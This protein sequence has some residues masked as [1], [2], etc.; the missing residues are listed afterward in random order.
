MV[1]EA[2]SRTTQTADYVYVRSFCGQ[3]KSQ[4]SQCG[5]A[6]QS[7]APQA[8]SGQKVGYGFQVSL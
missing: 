7:G 4:R 3:R 2:E 5:F 8:C 1:G 6:I